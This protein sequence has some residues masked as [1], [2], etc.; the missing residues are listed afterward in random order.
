MTNWERRR[1]LRQR[2][3]LPGRASRLPDARRAAA[4]RE[5]RARVSRAGVRALPRRAPQG[6]HSESRRALQPR[7]QVRRDARVREA[8]RRG[9]IATGH[10]ASASRTRRRDGRCSCSRPATPRTRATS[11]HAVDAADLA[12]RAVPARRSAQVRRAR[13]RAQSR[14]AR[15]RKEGQHR[16]LLHRRAAVRRVPRA[17]PAAVARQDRRRPRPRA[18]ARTTG[19]RT[20]RSASATACTSA[21]SRTAPRR[22]GTSRART[23]SATSSSSSRATTIRCC[24]TT[25]SPRA[26]RIG[27]AMRRT[28]SRPAR[29][30]VAC[31]KIRYRQPDQL[32]TV[33]RAG[34]AGSR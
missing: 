17:V 22:R 20:T 27:S 1:L 31:A 2:A 10:Y 4:P 32:C 19:S 12:R 14:P 26:N 13:D 25:G 16:H 34:D 3:R 18:R 29:R 30:S 15:R 7:D 23:R 24:S 6:P 28:D 9:A 33:V 8:A 5:L 21:A 11:S